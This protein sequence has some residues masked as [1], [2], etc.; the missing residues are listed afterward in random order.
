MAASLQYFAIKLCQRMP[1]HQHTAGQCSQS[2]PEE[3][4]DPCR[5]DVKYYSSDNCSL[6]PVS[7][8]HDTPQITVLRNS[9]NLELLA[10]EGQI[11]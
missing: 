3:S 6:E 1:Q 9:S 4:A 7:A 2:F 11:E 5:C 8:N 10:F